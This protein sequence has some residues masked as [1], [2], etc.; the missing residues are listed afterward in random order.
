MLKLLSGSPDRWRVLR[1]GVCWSAG[2]SV[3]F[4]FLWVVSFGPTH[5]VVSVLAGVTMGVM[6]RFFDAGQEKRLR[7]IGAGLSAKEH[8]RATGRYTRT[9]T[10]SSA[11]S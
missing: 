6:F 5:W 7:S 9:A 1:V 2:A 3:L 8:A 4:G 11:S 10:D